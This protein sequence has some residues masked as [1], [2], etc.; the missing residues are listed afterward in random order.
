[1]RDPKTRTI[2]ASKFRDR[3]IHHALVNVLEPIFEKIF[4]Y[5][6][7]ASRKNKGAHVAIKRFDE[8]K[9]KV[10]QN[11]LVIRGAG[12]TCQN[13]IMRFKGMSSKQT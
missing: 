4:I 2:H 8:F 11:G 5:D 13:V 7:Y 3:V 9:R 12:E 6:S 10:S 1:M